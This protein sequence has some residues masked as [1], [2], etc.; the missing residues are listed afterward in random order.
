MRQHRQEFILVT[1]RV[2][3]G[4]FDQLATRNIVI[5]NRQFAIARTAHADFQPGAGVG[6]HGNILLERFGYAGGKHAPVHR[7]D[8]GAERARPDI[9]VILADHV[10]AV[11][12]TQPQ[13]LRIHLPYPPMRV[14]NAKAFGH[15]LEDVAAVVALGTQLGLGADTFDRRPGPLGHV[16][17]QQDVLRTPVIGRYLMQ[18][19]NNGELAITHQRYRQAGN[20]VD[21]RIGLRMLGSARIGRRIGTGEYPTGTQFGNVVRSEFVQRPCHASDIVKAA[22]LPFRTDKK[23]LLVVIDLAKHHPCHAKET[24]QL[25][26]GRRHHIVQRRQRA[27]P[28]RQRQLE[29]LLTFGNFEATYLVGQLVIETGQLPML[30]NLCSDVVA[31]D[32]YAIDGAIGIP[33]RLVDKIKVMQ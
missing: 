14:K 21:A 11:A 3:Q 28:V 13:S 4:L 2:A 5:K 24:T 7:F 6:R 17:R 22:A 23:C 18:V 20:D 29:A 33:H 19:K 16:E 32:E 26:A 25:F 1:G 30:M 15:V 27:Q 8:L 10:N 9:P 12:L 31:F